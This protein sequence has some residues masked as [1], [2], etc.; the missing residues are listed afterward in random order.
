MQQ[1]DLDIT[2]LDFNTPLFGPT[3]SLKT[4]SSLPSTDYQNDENYKY[5]APHRGRVKTEEEQVSDESESN[6][7]R[8]VSFEVTF[9][10]FIT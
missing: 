3:T 4:T 9:L 8:C 1:A 7:S 10:Q 6:N 2:K 5:S